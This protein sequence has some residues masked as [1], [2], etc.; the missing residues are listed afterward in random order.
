LAPDQ[1]TSVVNSGDG[2][3]IVLQTEWG[4]GFRMGIRQISLDGVQQWYAYPDGRQKTP[5]GYSCCSSSQPV[6][7]QPLRNGG[8]IVTGYRVNNNASDYGIHTNIIL[9]EL[10]ETGKPK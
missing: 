4:N 10:D 9:L 8:T 2:N 6:A 5:G 1:V 7:I 3:L